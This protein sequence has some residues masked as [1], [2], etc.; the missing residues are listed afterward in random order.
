MSCI[1]LRHLDQIRERSQRILSTNRDVL[2]RFLSERPDLEAP[3]FTA[4]TVSF[5]RV[6]A[7]V[8]DLCNL[9]RE[10]YDTTVVPGR[11]FGLPE[12]VRI[13][14]GC[15]VNIFADGIRRVGLALDDLR[16]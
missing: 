15:E 4:G 5:P 6:R 12:H 2:D 16:S 13:G 10:K 9:L 3:R 7:S 1:A 8:A 11:F 14:L